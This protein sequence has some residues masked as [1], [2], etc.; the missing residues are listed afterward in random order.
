MTDKL[1]LM[2]R[3]LAGLVPANER[4][5]QFLSRIKIGATLSMPKPKQPRNIRFHNKLFAMLQIILDNQDHYKSIDDLLDVCKLRVG[6]VHV[7]GTKHG[8]VR[9]PKS[10]SFA[11]MS[12]DEFAEFYDRAV[13]WVTSEVIPGLTRSDLDAAVEASLLEFAA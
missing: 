9:L 3:T 1:I 6:H 5:V 10:I 13:D 8:D 7:I 12:A 2:R 4:A 11:S